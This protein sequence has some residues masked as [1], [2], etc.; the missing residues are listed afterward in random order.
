MKRIILVATVVSAV[1]SAHAA[2][3]YYN[4]PWQPIF[5]GVEHCTGYSATPTNTSPSGYY[6]NVINALR[7]DLW[8]P[9]VQI[10]TTEPVTNNYQANSRETLTQRPSGFLKEKGLK[11]A[12]NGAH[13]GGTTGYTSPPGSPAWIHGFAISQGKF[14]SPYDSSGE[15]DAL[16]TFTTNKVPGFIADATPIGNTNGIY[17]AIPGMYTLVNA[18]VNIGATYSPTEGTIHAIQPRTAIG[19]SQDGRY[20]ILLVIDGRQ[21]GYSVGAYDSETAEWLIRF[22]CYY[23]MNLDGGGSTAMVM[24]NECGDSVTLNEPTVEQLYGYQRPVGHNIGIATK[25]LPTAFFQDPIVT[26]GRTM[27]V[28]TWT[29]PLPATTQVEHGRTT[30]L[31]TYTPLDAALQTNHSVVLVGLTPGTTNYFR[32]ISLSNGVERSSPICYFTTKTASLQTNTV[33]LFDITKS[34]RYTSNNLD[35]VQWTAVSY[36]DSGWMGEGPGLLYAEDNA[37][38]APKNTPLPTPCGYG[39]Q[40]GSSSNPQMQRT[41]YFRTH[42]QFTGVPANTTLTFSNYLDDGAVFYLNGQEIQRV[43]MPGPPTN[44]TF[45]NLATGFSAG[46]PKY[47]QSQPQYGDAV[48]NE[49]VLF[50]ISGPVVATNLVQGDNVLA[51]ELHNYTPGSPD[52]VFGSALFAL[53]GSPATNALVV[54]SSDPG[55]NVPVAI[56]P[57]DP[58]GDSDGITPLERMYGSGDSPAVTAPLTVGGKVFSKWL[59]NGADYSTNPSVTISMT[60]SRVLTAVYSNPQWTLS[61]SSTN[62]ASGVAIEISPLD[63][64]SNGNGSTPF[65]RLY[66]NGTVVTLGAPLLVGNNR[67]TEWRAEG[68]TY[69]TNPV[70][71]ISME[72][73]RQLTA[74]YSAPVLFTLTLTSTNPESGV[75]VTVSPN[76][77][78]GDGNGL[79][80]FT[81]LYTNNAVVTATAP[82]NAGAN[83]FSAWLLN[84]APYST[85]ASVVVTLA[86]NQI[87]TAIYLSPPPT[88]PVLAV[89]KQN[90][91]IMLNWTNAGFLLQYSTNSKIIEWLDVPGPVTQGPYSEFLTNQLKLYRLKQQ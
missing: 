60:T 80:P 36:N 39:V 43:R 63:L 73:N 42:F 58:F 23:G 22:G 65:S 40:C 54:I 4:N 18:G 33:K 10:V 86:T 77:E 69:S 64:N 24:A 26:A 49:P 71:T 11:V 52:M 25:T 35:G 16:M 88:P 34:W 62:P 79:T 67:F 9:D 30:A 45:T 81:R 51:V 48:T 57:A 61:V 13:F 91:N 20:L 53:S 82:Q 83:L 46:P 84:G 19:Y 6:T 8:D 5:K 75:P 55:L 76:D 37:Y 27:A 50:T 87:L 78:N 85:N 47:S 70:I 28:L 72:T 44:I 29:T 90:N 17:H 21:S 31:G 89:Q 38:V 1:L 68:A 59:L 7:V 3:Y 66:N 14:T 12:V 2:T 74:V 32:L 56:S 15:A 41:Y